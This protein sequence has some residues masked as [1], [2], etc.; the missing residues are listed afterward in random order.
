M[1]HTMGRRATSAALFVHVVRPAFERRVEQDL[2]RTSHAAGCTGETTKHG[3]TP[4]TEKV[5]HRQFKESTTTT[6]TVVDLF[7]GPTSGGDSSM[8][9]EIPTRAT[10]AAG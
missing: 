10:H 1:E 5:L 7:R 4:T 2:F 9:R 3:S 8:Q 6:T